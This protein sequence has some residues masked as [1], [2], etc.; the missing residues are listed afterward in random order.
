[1]DGD[2][3]WRLGPADAELASEVAVAVA[4]AAAQSGVNPDQVSEWLG[5]RRSGVTWTVGHTDL[6]ASPRER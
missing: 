2:S 3:P 4:S 5:A 6:I 1:M